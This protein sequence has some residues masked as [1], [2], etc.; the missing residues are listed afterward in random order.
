M[1]IVNALKFLIEHGGHEKKKGII[2]PKRRWTFHK[3]TSFGK[4]G[5]I[6][7]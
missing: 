7:F 3:N 1:E 4:K 2:Y 6:E 5:K